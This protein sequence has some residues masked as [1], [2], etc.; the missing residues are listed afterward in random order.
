MVLRLL[1]S[2]YFIVFF[3][4]KIG[5]PVVVIGYGQNDDET[6]LNMADQRIYSKEL[7]EDRYSPETASEESALKIRVELPHGFDDSIFCSGKNFFI[8]C[9]LRQILMQV[10]YP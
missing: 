2:L 7:C 9:T 3:S 8:P 4:K 10:K 5:E 1:W 6:T